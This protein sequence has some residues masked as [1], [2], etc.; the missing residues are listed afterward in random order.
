MTFQNPGVLG[1]QCKDRDW[2]MKYFHLIQFFPYCLLTSLSHRWPTVWLNL[3][4]N[5]ILHLWCERLT[6][7]KSMPA[8]LYL[9][10]V[11]I[12]VRLPP[13]FQPAISCQVW[14]SSA[15]SFPTAP[16]K[17]KWGNT[18]TICAILT[19]PLKNNVVLW[20]NFQFIM[21]FYQ[22]WATSWSS[23]TLK[24]PSPALCVC[25]LDVN[26]GGVF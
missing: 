6:F 9:Y 5:S 3:A 25:C 7:T 24:F 10:A 8:R 2:L 17:L 21:Q 1:K 13:L 4:A 15:S 23:S 22:D 19:W 16:G 26:V 12:L 18:I 14:S 11:F 20:T